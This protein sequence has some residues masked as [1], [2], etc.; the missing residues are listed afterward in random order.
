LVEIACFE[1]NRSLISPALN[2]LSS[3]RKRKTSPPK[4]SS[5]RHWS[6]I[7]VM[8]PFTSPILTATKSSSRKSIS[9]GLCTI[10]LWYRCAQG[11][12][13]WE[14]VCLWHK[15][16]VRRTQ[17]MLIRSQ[18]DALNA[19]VVIQR[20]IGVAVTSAAT[21]WY[22]DSN[23]VPKIWLTINSRS[24]EEIPAEPAVALLQASVTSELFGISAKEVSPWYAGGLCIRLHLQ[25]V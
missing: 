17:N 5:T 2:A 14:N 15:F 10:R 25:K 13:T 24:A 1:R 18:H 11:V 4:R 7:G 22:G 8:L 6:A 20:N 21:H 3:R 12:R 9:A 23:C 16:P 19:Q